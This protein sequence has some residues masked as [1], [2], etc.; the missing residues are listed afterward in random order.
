[1]RLVGADC[2]RWSEVRGRRS[3]C[4]CTCLRYNSE[5]IFITQMR[6]AAGIELD[7]HVKGEGEGEGHTRGGK[8]LLARMLT[9]IRP[10]LPGPV[11]M[12]FF[13]PEGLHSIF[14]VHRVWT[15]WH[16]K[17]LPGYSGKH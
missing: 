5:P 2:G 13:N 14:Q 16:I 11:E 8:C 9:E 1:M 4:G 7:G 17:Q 12:C 15:L 10:F 3:G 6:W